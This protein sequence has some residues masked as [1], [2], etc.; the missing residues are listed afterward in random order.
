MAGGSQITL[1]GVRLNW[2]F[3]DTIF[4]DEYEGPEMDC[5]RCVELILQLCLLQILMVISES[6]CLMGPPPYQQIIRTL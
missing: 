3:L 2:L 4:Y 1:V 5:I 6:Q